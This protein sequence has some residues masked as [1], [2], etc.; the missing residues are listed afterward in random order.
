MKPK[1]LSIAFFILIQ[2]SNINAQNHA[3]I[4][5]KRNIIGYNGDIWTGPFGYMGK[6]SYERMIDYRTNVGIAYTRSSMSTPID[7]NTYDYNGRVYTEIDGKN[8]YIDEY[9]GIDGNFNYRIRGFE[10]YVKRFRKKNP[11][12]NFGVFWTYRIGRHHIETTVPEGA[13]FMIQ[14]TMFESKFDPYYSTNDSK[15]NIRQM[16]AGFELGKIYP[17]FNGKIL[18]SLSASININFNRVPKENEITFKEYSNGIA[19]SYIAGNQ[20]FTL[21]FGFA[22]AL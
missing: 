5:G 2:F 14:D 4:I 13:R 7:E 8:R 6:F 16:Y 21:N 22:Y 12:R 19:G 1:Q 11:M 3:G 18:F 9:S 17:W 20:L 15:F 10:L